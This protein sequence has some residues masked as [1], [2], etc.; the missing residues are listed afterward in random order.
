MAGVLA[1]F[2][3]TGAP[4]PSR[5]R[6]NRETIYRGTDPLSGA[7]VW[8]LTSAAI[9][10]HNIYGEQLYCS[11]DGNRVGLLRNHTT[12][13]RD[14]PMDLCV[15]DLRNQSVLTIGPAAFF[16][17]AGCGERNL[18]YYVRRDAGDVPRITRLN[19]VTLE[20]TDVFAFGECPPPE[21]RGLLA[22]SPDDRH[23]MILRRL[24]GR[25]Y[26]IERIDLVTGTW[27]Q[28][29]EA[30]DIFNAHLQFNPAGNDLMVQ[31]NRGGILDESFNVIRSVGPEGATLYVI[32]S[33]G[34]NLRRLPVGTPHTTPVTGHECWLGRTG[35]LL[36]TTRG[37]KVYT[38]GPGEAEPTLVTARPGFN[39]ITASPDGR[40]F[41]VD[42]FST[43]RLYV[44]C[45][46]TRRVLPFCDS[47]ASCGSPQYTH[48]H[49][50]ITPGN[51]HVIYNSDRTGV[52]QVYAAE[53]PGDLLAKLESGA[54]E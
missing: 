25:R 46:A 15:A 23:V 48:T 33:D 4:S 8:Q 26:G 5:V 24:G 17:V 18:L 44:G 1:K 12:D 50:Y 38:V 53:I 28:I 14:G 29:H 37:G 32:D 49:P 43:G 16:L 22:V 42:D 9:I 36:L 11:A 20:Q 51:R 54:G 39:H 6:W 52:P 31:H 30:D 34:G 27:R 47:G 45:L 35:R 21:F 19:L 41:V 40:F 2:P 10:T 3:C 7:K 13:H